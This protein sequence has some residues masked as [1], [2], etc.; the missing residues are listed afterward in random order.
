[1]GFAVTDHLKVLCLKR[2]LFSVA[3]DSA[4]GEGVASMLRLL[5]TCS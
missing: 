3:Q 4:D 5:S 1:M 2:N